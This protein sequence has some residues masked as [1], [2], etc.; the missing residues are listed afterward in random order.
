VRGALGVGLP[1]VREGGR[2][3][4]QDLGAHAVI[5]S[6]SAGGGRKPGEPGEEARNQAPEASTSMLNRSE[7][8]IA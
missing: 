8:R 2:I 6:S 5:M 3:L 7:K 4:G 1:F